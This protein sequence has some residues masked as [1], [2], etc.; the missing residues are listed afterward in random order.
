ML[1]LFSQWKFRHFLY[2]H[3][4]F[5]LGLVVFEPNWITLLGDFLVFV[6]I[7]Q[8]I[9]SNIL[10]QYFNHNYVVFKND[11]VEW[12]ALLF[13]TTYSFWR[14]TDLKS[15]HVC[16]HTQWLTDKDPTATEIAQGKIRY[17]LGLTAPSAI[18]QITAKENPKLTWINRH[19]LVVKLAIYLAVVVLF[20]FE[21][22]WHLVLAQQFFAY[23][24]AK[25]HD[26][27]FHSSTASQDKPWLFPLYYNDAWHIE[28][29]KE[30]TDPTPWHWRSINLQ[31]WYAR[32]LFK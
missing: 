6:L 7:I 24:L 23:G 18:P 15:Y 22:L 1:K 2:V 27:L 9:G 3:L 19:F 32:L 29:H 10:H 31:Y 26:M 28:H 13:L 14:P 16:H 25:S 12:A 5:L 4:T 21:A 8:P 30:F 17:Y 20:G 11:T